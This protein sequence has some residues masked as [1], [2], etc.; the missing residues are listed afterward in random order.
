M[1]YTIKNEFYSM[2]IDTCGAEMT[3]LKD[4]SGFEHMWQNKPDFWNRHAPLLF[5]VCGKLKDAKY[6]YHQKEY[7]MQ[8][9]GFI[10]KC[11]FNLVKCADGHIVMEFSAND[12]TKKIYPFDFTVT[13]HYALCGNTVDFS[14]TVKNDGEEMLPYMFGW[15]PAFSLSEENGADIENY[16]LTFAGHDKLSWQPLQN[17]PF[18]RPDAEDYPLTDEAYRL[19]EKEIYENDTMIFTGHDNA[20]VMTNDLN[21]YKLNIRWSENLPALCIWKWPDNAAKYIC[22]EPWSSTPADGIIDENFETRKMARL[23]PGKT[24]VYSDSFEVKA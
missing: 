13:A 23:A 16:K 3:S 9:H 18:V 19:S 7:E 10:G 11:E 17:G 12:E 6:T 4:A 8:G 1:E 15:H 14:F 5:P 22:I 24:E 21:S 20:L 2:T